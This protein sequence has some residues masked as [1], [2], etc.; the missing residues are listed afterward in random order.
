MQLCSYCLQ[1][2]GGQSSTLELTK[3]I[4]RFQT[5]LSSL[6]TT[7]CGPFGPASNFHEKMV[8]LGWPTGVLLLI[9]TWIVFGQ[10][11]PKPLEEQWTGFQSNSAKILLG[12][13]D[14]G[15]G[16]TEVAGLTAKSSFC[17][18]GKYRG[19]LK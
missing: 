4:L 2:S 11:T 18:K 10:E 8:P 1:N 9:L 5:L 15:K 3:L 17:P 12:G 19:R 14:Q 13:Y 16:V 6:D 7:I